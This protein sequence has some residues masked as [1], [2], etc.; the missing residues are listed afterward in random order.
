MKSSL[1]MHT[2][3]LR[4]LPLRYVSALHPETFTNTLDVSYAVLQ[5]LGIQNNMSFLT[6]HH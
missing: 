3:T 4:Y 6:G 2:D 1:T 5:V